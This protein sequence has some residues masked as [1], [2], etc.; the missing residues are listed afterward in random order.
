MGFEWFV[1]QSTMTDL[2]SKPKILDAPV[3]RSRLESWMAAARASNPTIL[4][5]GKIES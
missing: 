5:S 1:L 4:S 2:A 3:D